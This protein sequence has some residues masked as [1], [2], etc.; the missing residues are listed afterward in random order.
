[1]EPEASEEGIPPVP[2]PMLDADALG[3]Q[4]ASHYAPQS[5]ITDAFSED[6]AY[7]VGQYCIYLNRLYKFSEAKAEGPW[8]ESKV[9]ACTV[10]GEIG[11]LNLSIRNKV[12]AYPKQLSSPPTETGNISYFFNVT[13]NW[14]NGIVASSKGFFVSFGADAVVI[15]ANYQ[16]LWFSFRNNGSW[17]AAVQ[18]K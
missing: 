16:H 17:I 10:L 1:M 18:V 13:A 9:E 5:Q 8:D 15:A 2:E 6:K 7:T 3:G 14:S 4:P 12:D 11:A